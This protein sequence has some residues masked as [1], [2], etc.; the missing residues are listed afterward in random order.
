MCYILREIL[1]FPQFNV[2]LL[3]SVPIAFMRTPHTSLTIF[4]FWGQ[5]TEAQ[6]ISNAKLTTHPSTSILISVIS[7]FRN[8][9]KRES[10]SVCWH[11]EWLV[12]SRGSI[13][14][15]TLTVTAAM[16][17]V[18]IVW[19]PFWHPVHSAAVS[20]SSQACQDTWSAPLQ[21]F[22]LELVWDPI[23]TTTLPYIFNAQR[24]QQ[25]CGE[26]YWSVW[27]ELKRLYG[28]CFSWFESVFILRSGLHCMYVSNI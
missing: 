20:Y 1:Q 6:C 27:R 23:K 2:L 13:K 7:S 18:I 5:A 15:S 22:L 14:G 28:N 10:Y 21:G 3:D 4:I 19:V 26:T 16:P 25:K 12:W 17:W 8:V 9:D 24:T 11:L